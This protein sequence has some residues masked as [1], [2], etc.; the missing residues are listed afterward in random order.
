M[1]RAASPEIFARITADNQPACY[2][3]SPLQKP[4]VADPAAFTLAFTTLDDDLTDLWATRILP[5]LPGAG[6]TLGEKSYGV[7]T[8]ETETTT[9]ADLIQQHTLSAEPP[10]RGL[11]L[12]FR[13]PVTFHSGGSQFPF[14]T[15]DLVF[16]GL[17]DR[18]N[19]LCDIQLHPDTRTFARECIRISR[20]R[21]ES[22]RVDTGDSPYGVLTGGTGDCR[23]V[24]WRGDEYWQ[25]VVHALA[26]FSRFAGVGARTS[27]GMGQVEVLPGRG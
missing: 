12:R 6:I 21:M 9:D 2:T 16:G 11:T 1:T 14:P 26:A 10:Q 8:V 5:V 19:S 13:T 7:V 27:I 17:L 3:V 20:Y 25:R 18:W 15:P 24:V 23:Y 22:R 4:A